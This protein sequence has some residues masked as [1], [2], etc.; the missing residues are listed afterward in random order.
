MQLIYAQSLDDLSSM[1]LYMMLKLRQDIFIIEQDCIYND[2]DNYD[3]LC[4]HLL[5]KDGTNVV[6]CARIVPENTKFNQLSIGRVAVHKEY[7]RQGLGKEMM[8][9]ALEVLSKKNIDTVIIEAQSYL[10]AF[11]ESLGFHKISEAYT[12]D[13]IS[14]HK[15]IYRY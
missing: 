13:G 3:P 7:R 6:A 14:H 4:E 1:D 10:M 9:K 5:L 11:Y 15:M 8:L 2:L 12:V